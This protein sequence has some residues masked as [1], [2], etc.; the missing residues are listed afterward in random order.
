MKDIH[1][2]NQIL[3]FNGSEMKNDRTLQDYGIFSSVT[4]QLLEKE[5]DNEMGLAAGGKMKQKIYE[6]DECNINMYNLKKVT[7]VFVN[8]ANGNMW[9]KITGNALP[10]SPINPKMYKMY[11]YPWFALYD[12]SM[13]DVAANE[14][15]ANV[16]SIN[17]IEND[18]NK[19]WNC[20]LCTFENVA[21]NE[22]C[23]MCNQGKKP[24]SNKNKDNDNAKNSLEIDEATQ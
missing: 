11:G 5:E 10:E 1:V 24:N 4:I 8:I 6:D 2:Q 17:E 16:K 9:R 7:R 22:I 18:P 14:D 23:C 15:L 19:P 21:K 13:A 3:M 20:P 12:D